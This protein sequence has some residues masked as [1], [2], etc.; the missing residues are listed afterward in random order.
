MILLVHGWGFDATVWDGVRAAL[1]AGLE[2][3]ALD[4]GFFGA[5]TAV[6]YSVTL[7]VGHSLGA[8]WLLRQGI[9][10]VLAVNGFPRFTAA[11]DFPQGVAPRMVERMARRLADAP[12]EVVDAFRDRCGA[13]PATAAPDVDR[14]AWGLDL[15]LSADARPA[16]P[17]RAIAG[18]QDPIVPPPMTEAAFGAAVTWIDGGHLLPLTHPAPLAQAILEALP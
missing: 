5:P 12:A 6:P 11:P 2:V 4:L 18:R 8:L 13:G 10:P 9:A 7:A 14:L 17:L 3:E 1:P 15:L 16:A